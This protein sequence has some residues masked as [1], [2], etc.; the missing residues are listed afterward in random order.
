MT[1]ITNFGGEV[2]AGDLVLAGVC[3]RCGGKVARLLELSSANVKVRENAIW[4][5]R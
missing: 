1:T 5:V 2:V 4:K 3:Q